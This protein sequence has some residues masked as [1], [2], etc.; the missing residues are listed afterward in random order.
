M[1]LKKDLL[2]T[3]LLGT[4][5]QELPPVYKSA[6]ESLESAMSQI[7]EQVA[8]AGKETSL[9]KAVALLHLFEKS[10][11]KAQV[12]DEDF[13]FQK[14]TAQ[15]LPEESDDESVQNQMRQL[16]HEAKTQLRHLLETNSQLLPEWLSLAHKKGKTIPAE[17]LVSAFELAARNNGIRKAIASCAGERGQWLALLNEDWHF[18]L[19]GPRQAEANAEELKK[20]WDFGSRQERLAALKA[21]RE[22][23]PSLA[24]EM[25]KSSWKSDPP[26]ERLAYLSILNSALSQADESFLESAG[27][28]DKRKEIRRQSQDLLANIAGSRFCLRNKERLANAVKLKARETNSGFLEKL[29]SFGKKK[30]SKYELEVNLPADCDK[31]MIRDGFSAKSPDARMGDKAWLLCQ[32]LGLCRPSELLAYFQLSEEELLQVFLE[33]EWRNALIAGLEHACL[34]FEASK[35]AELILLLYFGLLDFSAE[36]L[37]LKAAYELFDCLDKKEQES[38]LT[39][40]LERNNYLLSKQGQ[41]YVDSRALELLRR[42]RGDWSKEFSQVVLRAIRTHMVQKNNSIFS[43]YY[44]SPLALKMNLEVWAAVEASW[45]SSAVYDKSLDKMIATLNQRKEI[46]EALDCQH[47]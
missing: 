24:L 44:L 47:Q 13:P 4:G 21:A 2:A 28:D 6:S 45:K 39:K 5:Q 22:Q 10:G 19:I 1:W 26:E 37:H 41:E 33:S 17:L 7:Q 25:I 31:Q 16:S 18:L 32:I 30:A 20:L 11:R 34:K 43:D 36:G 46:K 3:A 15:N 27:L 9:L 38:F 12:L 23:E 14:E 8:D 35:Q 42:M 40:Y 29:A